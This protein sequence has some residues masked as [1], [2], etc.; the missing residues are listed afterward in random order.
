MQ[1]IVLFAQTMAEVGM[2]LLVHGEVTDPAVDIFDREQVFID[3]ILKPLMDTH[4][5]LKIVMEHITTE[6]AVRFI[7]SQVNVDGTP[8]LNIRATITPHHLLYNRNDIFKGGICPHMY[9]LPIL[10]REKHREALLEAA[11]S[12]DPHFFIGTDSAPHSTT[13]KESACG[14][15]G[16]FTGHGAV[17]LYAEAFDSVGKIDRLEDFVSHFGQEFYNLPINKRKIRL[18]QE[19]WAV[20]EYYA[21]GDEQL[22]PLRA[23]GVIHWRRHHL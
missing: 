2:P 18:V 12:G 16:I 19:D 8:N 20:P 6:N 13:A 11:T 22:R 17:E 5:T 10:K 1:L 15:A 23:G 14:C 21:F 4:P 7:R 9:C 3:T